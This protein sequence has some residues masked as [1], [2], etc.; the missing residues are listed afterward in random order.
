MP[1]V[2]VLI[3]GAGPTGLTLAVDLARRGVR[4]VLIEAAP[5]LPRQSRGKGLQPRSLEVLDDL[6]VVDAVLGHGQSRQD[7]TL[8]RDGRRLARIPAGLT[9][10]RADLPYPNI[11]MIPQW[12][13]TTLLA[14]RLHELGSAIRFDTRLESF[15]AGSDAVR[16]VVTTPDGG[17]E[18][19]TVRYLVGCDGAHSIVR[20]T[21][22]LEFAGSSDETQRY[23][24]GDITVP[25]W[26]PEVDGAVRSHAWLGT[27][28]SF[29]GLAGLPGTG[30]WQI[31]ASITADDDLE[32]TLEALQRL[33]NERTGHPQVRLSDA[34]WLSNFRVNVRMV[35]DYRRG[36]VLLAGDAA[37]VHPPTGGQGMNTGIQDA[38][39][40]GWKLAA[41]LNGNDDTLL[42]TYP[43]ERLPVA[44]RALAQSTNILDV[45]TNRN[46]LV[47]FA[48]QRLLLPLL[49]RPSINRR[50]TARVSQIDIGYHDGPLADDE[51][52]GGRVRPGDRAPD[53]RL[54][55]TATGQPLRLFDLLRGP[56]WTL[57]LV[58]D[59]AA[60]R[61]DCDALPD[62]VRT[63]LIM[64]ARSTS[65]SG[66]VV[67]DR[68]GTFRRAYRAKPGTALLIRP[69]GYL[70]W[71]AHT[72]CADAVA[73]HVLGAG[74]HPHPLPPPDDSRA[75]EKAKTR[76]RAEPLP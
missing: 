43:A 69:D 50:L 40:L 4:A 59:A 70:H 26:H 65:F 60:G 46:P 51:L 24:L 75:R 12:R 6:G 47:R 32:P 16:A 48:V 62:E 28:G 5:A 21:L 3:V 54:V 68:D 15:T 36:R 49:S 64:P 33:W 27:D 45:I 31:G 7:I 8:Y 37:H 10:P 18:D 42:D 61:L 13:T 63:C 20:R 67:I 56:Q 72:P 41:C 66:R 73:K 55:D 38:Y 74:A 39:N 22:D 19:L 23:L 9:E 1:A 34:T 2:D 29:L 58:G 57:L 76:R 53:A 52:S 17:R 30:Q 71:R 25:G 35:E 44:R 14:R 11:V